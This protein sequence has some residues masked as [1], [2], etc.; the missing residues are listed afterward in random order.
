MTPRRNVDSVN[1]RAITALAGGKAAALV[2]RRLTHSG[3]TSLPGLIASRIDADTIKRVVSQLGHGSIVV[4]GTNG[5]T[6]TARM[7]SQIASAAGLSV[8]HNRSGSNLMRGLASTVVA[9]AD[10]FGRLPSAERMIGVFE[11][12][13]ATLP[14][15][16]PQLQPRAVVFLNLFR[17]QLDRYG[18]VD[19]I[20]GAWRSALRQLEN[21]T[22]VVLNADDPSVASLA[23]D[24]HGEVITFGVQDE[25]HASAEEHASDARW[26]PTCGSNYLYEAQYFGH[27]GVWRCPGCAASRPIPDVRA[28]EVDLPA[29][30]P[31]LLRMETPIGELNLTLQLEG[32]YNAYNALA[33]VAGAVALNV[34]ETAIRAGLAELV[35][36]F[37]RGEAMLVD[38]RHVHLFL[39]KNPAG[40]NQVLRLLAANPVKKSLL[41]ILNDGIADGRDIS[42]I[43]DVDFES[44]TCQS[45]SIVVSGSRAADMAL[46]LKYAGSGD[47]LLIEPD[48]QRALD[49]AL[50][51]TRE[52]GHLYTLPTYTAMLSVRERL[53]SLAG[54]SH[55]WEN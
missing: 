16:L 7:L 23:T 5:K 10:T 48:E 35:A 53:A 14:L 52:G 18:E 46:R 1:L 21:R 42:W 9:A 45:E 11:V 3:G 17:D 12:D 22:V 28:I 2:S 13:E 41:L 49:L 43:W 37:G 26:C 31:M 44:L 24:W 4:T 36:A 32:L 29:Q 27:I 34:P 40:T 39:C 51:V 20:S 55:F 15:A 30:A 8:L 19:S 50:S 33:A 38:N 25:T 47:A 6:T 54:Y